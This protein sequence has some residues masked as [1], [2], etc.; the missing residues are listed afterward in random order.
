MYKKWL[1]K[2][3][4]IL[5]QDYKEK[6]AIDIAVLLGRSLKS[7]Q[8][9]IVRLGLTKKWSHKEIEILY[10]FYPQEGGLML[11]RLTN[12]TITGIHNKVQMLGIKNHNKKLSQKP[13]I[14]NLGLNKIIAKCKHHGLTI[15]YYYKHNK[16]SKCIKCHREWL[17]KHRK[18]PLGNYK[19][20]IQ[21][22]LRSYAKHQI[23]FSKHLVYSAEDLCKHLERIR[24]NQKDKC[25]MCSISYGINSYDIDHI[26]PLS[27]ANTI[28]QL[29]KLYSLNNL[30]LLCFR[31]NRFIKRNRLLFV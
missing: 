15:Y 22:S 29:K 12:R 10:E 20:R 31:C 13:I 21:S 19:S 1:K 8:S 27:S 14:Q 2:D 11:K 30:T 28:D 7:V 23:H 5:M 16:R 3:N 17:K 18:S 26:I 4:N 25:P 24:Q 6:S 9:Q